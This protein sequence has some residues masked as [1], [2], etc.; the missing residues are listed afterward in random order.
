MPFLKVD[1]FRLYFEVAGSGYPILLLPPL[2]QDHVFLRPLAE[3]LTK[4]YTTICLDPPGHG[5]SDKPRNEELYS[6]EKLADCR[7]SLVQHLKIGQHDILGMSWSGRIALTYTIM[8]PD[9]VRA[10][11]LIASSSPK[12]QPRHPPETTEMSS[13]ERFLI[14][15]VWKMPYDVSA[16]LEK[17]K[18]PTLILIGDKDPRLE[19]AHFMHREIPKST[20]KIIKG[21]GH[22]FDLTI[23]VKDILSWL[24]ELPA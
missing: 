13:E 22:E 7:F 20:M 8:Y 18:I 24:N 16:D 11:L 23:C 1:S 15:T 6:Y 14:E 3:P 17:I 10:L 9:K 5:L 21:K 2:S 12:Y 19:A 4:T